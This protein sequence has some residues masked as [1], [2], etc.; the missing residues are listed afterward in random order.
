MNAPQ[1]PA[2]PTLLTRR[3][4]GPVFLLFTIGLLLTGLSTAQ[5]AAEDGQWDPPFGLPLIAIHAATLPTGDVL[6][7]SAEHGVPGIHG[8]LLDPA[9]LALTDVP[10]PPPWNPDCAGHEFL[11]DGRLL[12]AGGTMSFNPLTGTEKAFVFNPWTR[13]WTQVEDMRDGRWYPSN[14]TL[15]DGRVITMAGL[16][17]TPN[18]RMNTATST[19]AD[20]ARTRKGRLSATPRWRN[21]AAE[22]ESS[23]IETSCSQRL[24]EISMP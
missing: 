19:C 8:W 7:F 16:S 17:S 24:E 23:I 20:F 11:A 10:P 3:A 6:L 12:V 18:D 1:A 14:V 5:T 13:A 9:S 21:S 2:I 15:S 4:R 22:S